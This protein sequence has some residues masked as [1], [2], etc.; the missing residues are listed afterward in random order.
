MKNKAFIISHTHWD[1]EWYQPFQEFRLRLVKLVDKLLDIMAADPEYRFFMLDGQTVV[2][3]DY[4]EMRPE[5]EAQ[6]RAL[7]QEGRL[8]IGP[9]FILPDEFLVSPEAIVRNLLLGDRMARRFGGK[10][11][12]GYV[13]DQFG[14]ISQLPQIFRGFGMQDAV[15]WRGLDDH[16]FEL[17]WRGPGGE[18][19]LLVYLRGGY[20]N[21][22]HLPSGEPEAFV[23]TLG[24]LAS[25]LLPH[26]RSGCLPLMNGTDHMEPHPGLPSAIRYAAERLPELEIRHST[27]PQ[28]IQAIREA[29]GEGGIAALPLVEGELRSCKT[30]HLLPG[31]LSARTWIKQRNAAIQNLLERWA[32]PWAAFAEGA[33]QGIRLPLS[34]TRDVIGRAWRYLLEN[35]PHDSICGCSVDQ[36]HREMRT[37][38][39]WAE[40][41]GEQVS[42]QSLAAIAGAVQTTGGELALV[43]FNPLAGPR[44]DCAEA[45]VE[46]PPRLTEFVL[47]DDRGQEVPCQVLEREQ[48]EL[49]AMTVH[50]ELLRVAAGAA[51]DGIIQGKALWEVAVRR[52][53]AKAWL[54]LT[55]ADGGAA[56][57][58]ALQKWTGE[59]A[60]LLADEGVQ[61]VE[62]R[63][64]TP[65]R[66]K[67][68]FAASD[69]PGFGYRTYSLQTGV[70]GLKPD[71]L[72]AS[73]LGIEN[74]SLAVK[75]NPQDGTLSILHKPTGMRLQGAN[76]FADGGDRGDEYNYCPPEQDT[77]V[78][79]PCE[80]PVIRLVESGP[81]R[82]TLEIEMLYRVPEALAPGRAARSPHLITIPI[83]TRVS[84]SPGVPRCDI[85]TT[86]VNAARD[87]RLRVLVP[88]PIVT[89][90][91]S[92]EGHYD[93]VR[94]SLDLPA[95][96]A[97]WVE[98]PQP[99]FPQRAFCD[100][101]D[102][103]AGVMFAVRGLPEGEVMRGESGA[104]IAVTLL[105]C[106]EYLSRG[107]MSTRQGHAGPSTGNFTPDA[108]E[109]GEHTFHY[110]IIPHA[111]GWEQAFRQAHA[112]E[113]PLRA[114]Q[115]SAHEGALPATASLLT[116]RPDSLVITAVKVPEDGDGL[117]ARVCNYTG[118]AVEAEL[119]FGWPIRRAE[120]VNLAE[121]PLGPLAVADGGRVRFPCGPWEVATIRLRP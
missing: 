108:Q 28:Y 89:D 97:G 101:S 86:V 35:Q 68:A 27:M 106:V 82:A 52:E 36:V 34:P 71:L 58:A 120:R 19:V 25:E 75:A 63:A 18:D 73:G 81:A 72:A 23:E 62:V 40:Q 100:A 60:A 15:L 91:S 85:Q 83:T 48:E 21:A 8:L 12:V 50:P 79:A 55:L 88:T 38:F 77:I 29:L 26:S 5:R 20:G 57:P 44:T 107:D 3:E 93:V 32:E 31:V 61:E 121:E 4:L 67:I 96:A 54:D 39:D 112:H 2:L 16:P 117:I 7:V 78:T 118:H 14:H 9:W 103:E 45:T 84:L 46:L 24:T 105:R 43:V 113:T 65:V 66:C 80:K 11:K 10:M 33:L 110:S 98:E 1:R 49:L 74:E 6:M 116:A 95:D 76:R 102:G 99:T 13:P 92:A 115:T 30:Q 114:A 17:R 59:V 42:R 47:T 37:R 70:S 64:K 119:E 56:D 22:A 104:T 111:G 51:R 53:G 69:V 41:V 87:H 94:R 90:H 109:I